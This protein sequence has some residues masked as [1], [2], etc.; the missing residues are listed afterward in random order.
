MKSPVDQTIS[1]FGVCLCKQIFRRV[2]H[3]ASQVSVLP[4]DKNQ[5]EAGGADLYRWLQGHAQLHDGGRMWLCFVR[6]RDPANVQAVAPQ[7]TLIPGLDWTDSTPVNS[8]QDLAF[9]SSYCVYIAKCVPLQHITTLFSFL[10]MMTSW[11]IIIIIIIKFLQ[12]E[13][14]HWLLYHSL[15]NADYRQQRQ[16]ELRKI[17]YISA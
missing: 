13:P 16:K 5:Q 7:E 10:R 9:W 4:R 17:S 8:T 15:L 11:V 2:E 14:L 3:N 6:L 1:P 12:H